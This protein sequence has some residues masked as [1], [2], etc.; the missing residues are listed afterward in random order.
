[1]SPTPQKYAVSAHGIVKTFLSGSDKITALDS[2]DFE[3]KK[4]EF[5]AI[6]G[7]SGSGKSTLLH[8]L[9]GLIKPDAGSLE[10][11]G[12]TPADMSDKE[13]TVFRRDH[14]GLVF[15]AFNLLP[16]LTV[17]ENILLPILAGSQAS[18]SEERLT[19]VINSVG[20]D[21][22]RKQRA[23]ALSGGEQQRVAI[24][25][26]LITEPTLFLADEP[27]GNL[28]SVNGKKICDI[29]THLHEKE[30]RTLLVVTHESNV[31]LRAERIIILKDGRLIAD[32]P[33]SR[34]DDARDLALYYQSLV[35]TTSPDAE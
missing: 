23:D 9:S 7:A 15:Q 8:I 33:S 4:G 21:H 12:T 6:M 28:D 22:R 14:I 2:L 30:G 31:A 27:T 35:D 26:A 3:M 5:V 34:F 11:G 19:G 1:M 10:I 29:L 17:E 25:R 32:T 16:T 20:L 24:A 13:L 18:P